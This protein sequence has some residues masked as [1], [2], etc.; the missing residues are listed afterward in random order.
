MY[1]S[2]NSS[3]AQALSNFSTA[4]SALQTT[5]RQI[6][7]GKTVNDASD[8]AALWAMAT[9]NYSDNGALSAVASSQQG[10]AMPTISA[11]QTAIGGINS[12]MN[13]MR[14]NLVALQGGGDQSAILTSLQAQGKAL[15]S[16]VSNAGFN[17][18]NLLDSSTATSGSN[19]LLG[20][21]EWSGG[22]ESLN[23]TAGSL[24]NS[25]G[26]TGVLQNAQASGSS[27]ASDFTA[28]TANDV[29]TA[30]IAQT[31]ANLNA[32]QSQVQT[33]GGA[34]GASSN[35]V[36]Q[37]NSSV[38]TLQNNMANATAA[39]DQTNMDS[40]AAQLAAGNVS[41]QL[42]SLAT[43]IANRSSA[44]VLRLFQQQPLQS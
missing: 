42:A 6:S 29:S 5:M 8:N 17:G 44:N 41:E 19:F 27:Q 35:Q 23:V 31:L 30:N 1:V 22:A 14:D 2:F 26:P 39:M 15:T 28:L 36:G 13:D 18:V 43:T 10:L 25:S 34:V 4:Q 9:S 20:Y 24:T 40:A 11:S 12:V 21:S 7:T 32:A 3:S 16:A 33:I 37:A 38:L